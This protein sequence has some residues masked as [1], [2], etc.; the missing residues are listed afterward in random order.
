MIYLNNRFNF[1]SLFLHLILF[2]SN[3]LNIYNYKIVKK[4]RQSP[5]YD[6]LYTDNINLSNNLNINESSFN[7]QTYF[8]NNSIKIYALV[9]RSVVLKCKIELDEIN[10]LKSENY[11]VLK[12]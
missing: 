9:D 6:Y 12:F 8:K 4:P 11:K 2:L 10:F 7:P 5:Y 1:V 3:I